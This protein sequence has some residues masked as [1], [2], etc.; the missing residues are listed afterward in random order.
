MMCDQQLTVEY[1]ILTHPHPRL[2][3]PP[4]LPMLLLPQVL[5]FVA[6]FYGATLLTTSNADASLKES[7]RSHMTGT[8]STGIEAVATGRCGLCSTAL[9]VPVY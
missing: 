4:F 5:R 2:G 1:Y 7:F 8:I 3:I 9:A 6:H